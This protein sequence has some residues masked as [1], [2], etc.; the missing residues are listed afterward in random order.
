ME[1]SKLIPQEEQEETI[2]L[3]GKPYFC[4]DGNR[5]ALNYLQAARDALTKRDV[6][7]NPTDIQSAVTTPLQKFLSHSSRCKTCR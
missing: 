7:L 5:L 2:T 1:L 4:A 3:D 6:Q